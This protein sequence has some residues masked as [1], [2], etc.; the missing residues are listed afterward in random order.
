MDRVRC[1]VL[2][3]R[4][5][6]GQRFVEMLSGH[7]WFELGALFS[8]GEGVGRP[9]SEAVRWMIGPDVPGAASDIVMTEGAFSGVRRSGVDMVFSALPSEAAASIERKLSD[10]GIH[11]ISNSSFHRMD[12]DVPLVIPEVN[13]GHLSMLLDREEGILATNPNCTTTGLVMALAPI[14]DLLEGPVHVSSYQAISGAGYP[15]VPSLEALGTVLPYISGE[16]EKLIEEPVK[17]LGRL[18][19][20]MIVGSSIRI[21]PNCVRVGVRDGHLISFS[22][23]LKD[24][25]DIEEVKRRMGSFTGLEGLPS[26]PKRPLVLRKENDR[27][28]PDLDSFAGG[29]LGMSVSVG[30]VR[31]DEGM[32]RAFALVNNTIRGGAGNAVLIAEQCLK[33]GII[34]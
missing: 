1:G 6:I 13:G 11:V 29:P 22:A 32:L 31:V 16:E 5:I 33:E 26:A 4:G 10:S 27:P 20:G 30:R 2:G 14:A 28:R 34:R 12:P 21:V 15:G 7:P 23:S 9:Y 17:I 3:A 19:D 8:S 18:D 24:R 25:V